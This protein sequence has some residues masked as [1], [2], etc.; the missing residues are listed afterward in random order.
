MTINGW[1]QILI[2]SAA[3]LWPPSPQAFL[4]HEV[5]ARE[6]TFLDP[7]LRPV[8]KLIYKITR[9]DEKHEMRWTEYCISMLLFSAV[10]MLVLYLL[11]RTQQVLPLESAEASARLRPILLLTP[12]LLLRPTPT[13]SSIPASRP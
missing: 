11:Q 9:V 6:R 8:E 12:P 1:L 5:F 3:V 4:W 13:G 7:V 2:F 10:S